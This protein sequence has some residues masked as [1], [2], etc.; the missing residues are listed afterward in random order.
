M[1]ELAPGAEFAGYRVEGVAGKG[2]M[3]VVYRATQ[4]NLDRLVALKLIAADYAEDDDFR[5][6]FVRESRTAASIEHPNVIPVYEAGEHAGALFIS[7]RYVDGTDLREQLRAAG[8]LD[9]ARVA[10]L[11]TQIGAALDAAHA[12]GLVHRDVKPANV[13]VA[14][15]DHVYLTDFGLT[16][17]SES[18]S[19]L[20]QTGQFVGTYDYVAPEQ[21]EGRRVDA[22]TDV[23][24]L[25]CML[26]HVLTGT[27]PF[28]RPTDIA[29]LWAHV[30]DPPP[31][32]AAVDP[33]LADFQPVVDRAMEKEP[34]HRYAS[35]GDLGRAVA[36]VSAGRPVVVSEQSV[37]RGPAAPP[38]PAPDDPTRMDAPAPAPA[39]DAAVT[40]TT[41]RRRRTPLLVGGAIAGVA[42]AAVVAVLLLGGGGGD[43]E[44]PTGPELA[45]LSG[46][47]ATVTPIEFP[48]PNGVAPS[49]DG[50]WVT[51]YKEGNI[52]R[53]DGE[54][55]LSRAVKVGEGPG[56][57]VAGDGEV[58]VVNADAGN[59]MRVNVEA[60]TVVGTPVD[61]PSSASGDSIAL[62]PSL[63]WV[64]NV[65][66]GRLT[67]IDRKSLDSRLVVPPDGTAGEIAVHDG[68]LWVVG[69]HA[70]LSDL[71][72]VTGKIRGE[73]IRI[74]KPPK[75]DDSM[76]AELAVGDS[77]V[78]VALPDEEVVVRVD[79]QT[80]KIVKRIR[81]PENV[82]GDIVVADDAVY[83]IDESG[84][85]A[86]ID[87]K[88][89]KPTVS[90]PAPP[91]GAYDMTYTRG[92]L[93][94]ASSADEN[95][96]TRIGQ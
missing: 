83:V 9:P 57:I 33:G 52:R 14:P 5:E 89:N 85:P 48:A 51:S 11:F 59:V 2:G 96:V 73:P 91:A 46:A 70:T 50:V 54:G 35:A 61:I 58:W 34:E 49:G 36:A 71:D 37:A 72:P 87:P 17:R 62:T 39:P 15:G 27:V 24:A 25:G 66:E 3:G 74:G 42:A 55:K 45:P 84:K 38:K 6:R 88:T 94:I 19:A 1:S 95:T 76:L 7:M 44:E 10:P 20:T 65:S 90:L 93:W 67:R 75:G 60:A 77:G 26:F 32:L 30:N 64:V 82:G 86:R 22:R 63:V 16:K 47:S 92:A 4:L 31:R 53:V 68:R 13:L 80:H 41:P 56:P 78:W 12:R 28:E 21:I 29:K 18:E 8:R 69:D 81:I 23:Y 43:A 79:P 40:P